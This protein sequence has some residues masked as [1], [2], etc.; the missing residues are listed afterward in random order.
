MLKFQKSVEKTAKNVNEA[1]ELALE[2]LGVAEDE[3]I[4]EVLDEGTKGF[5]GIGS[6]EAKVRATLKNVE[7]YA[8]RQFLD[9]IFKAMSLEVA[10]DITLDK[11]LMKIELSGAHM[12]IVIGKR[13]DTLDSLQYLT[14]LIVNHES[15]G[16]IKVTIDTENYRQKREEALVALSERLADKV[17]RS[18]KKYTLEPMNPYERRIIHANL[19]SS[20]KVTTFS[21]GEE[22]YRKVVIA[23]KNARMYYNKRSSYQKHSSFEAYS[24]QG[25]MDSEDEI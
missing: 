11:D 12:G 20:E 10:I 5:L 17:A 2:A 3:A 18:G 22:P 4:V 8:A 16:Y 9:S 24:Q 13:G 19:Q 14:S 6:K 1:T 25:D 7:V 15:D 23:P 21:V